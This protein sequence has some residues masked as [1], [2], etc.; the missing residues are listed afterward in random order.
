MPW[1]NGD[2]SF[3]RIHRRYDELLG[4]YRQPQKAQRARRDRYDR[5]KR[6][7]DLNAAF[8]IVDE[9]LSDAAIDRIIDDL[10]RFPKPP[11][12]LMPHPEWDAGVPEA[13]APKPTNA[14][15]FAYANVLAEVLGGEVET[16]I[17]QIAR[18]GRTKLKD[19]QRFIWQPKFDGPVRHDC[20]YILVDDVCH[21]GGT[22]AALRSHIV[23]SGGTVV[24]ATALACNDGKDRE[25]PIAD[26][27]L[28]MLKLNIKEALDEIW[29]EEIGH[30]TTCLTEPEGSFLLQWRTGQ[31][32]GSGD[33]LL[34]RVRE[35]LATARA[36]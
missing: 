35:E 26:R 17:I 7:Y 25:F 19:F 33:A 11:R 32:S 23:A 20:A 9:L 14:L 27:T 18:P 28:R 21:F 8:E 5:A 3:I 10:E 4:T 30:D 34:Q 16:E 22:L 15:P 6:A 36:S 1:N 24:S 13:G 29:R 2:P 31:P 12:I